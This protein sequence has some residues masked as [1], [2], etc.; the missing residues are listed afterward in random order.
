MTRRKLR[1]IFKGESLRVPRKLEG[2]SA[3]PPQQRSADWIDV[4]WRYATKIDRK[5]CRRVR[6]NFGRGEAI[7][8]RKSLQ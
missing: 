7:S 8:S 5:D 3:V 4:D 1:I 2:Y 6:F